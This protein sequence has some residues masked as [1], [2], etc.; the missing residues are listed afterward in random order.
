MNL[1]LLPGSSWLCYKEVGVRKDPLWV[2]WG[3]VFG[4]PVKQ[5]SDVHTHTHKHT[6]ISQFQ[7][8]CHQSNYW[9]EWPMPVTIT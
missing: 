5:D 8:F 6:N 1:L 9:R 7:D 2:A 4:G 3:S